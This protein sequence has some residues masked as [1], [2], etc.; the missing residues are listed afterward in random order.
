MAIATKIRETEEVIGPDE[1]RK[2]LEGRG[3]NRKITQRNVDRLAAAMRNGEWIEEA[4]DPIRFNDR[5]ELVDG[6]HRLWAI[7]ETGL[8]FRFRVIRGLPDRVMDVLDTGRERTLK[9]FL[10][11]HGEHDA[12]TL[13][14]ALNFLWSWR[15]TA[16][17][18]VALWAAVRMTTRE[19]FAL[20]DECPGIRESIAKADPVA[21][22]IGGGRARWAALNYVLSTIT[23]ADTDDF[24]SKLATGEEVPKG[25]V[26]SLLRN[27]LLQD[28]SAMRRMPTRE[29]TA[30]VLKAWNL[31]RRG[32]RVQHLHWTGGGA[33][34]EPY[35]TP[36]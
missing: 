30:L 7:V 26:I 22:R 35:P 20:L 1:A 33:H 9:D 2:I 6:Q 21:H 12:P 11:I 5:D 23:A 36:E 32:T 27:R 4:G 16:E 34:P 10:E 29:Y 24:F 19:A 3:A 31:Y 15:Q 25:S 17:M 18:V 13:A 14:G 8:P 28:K